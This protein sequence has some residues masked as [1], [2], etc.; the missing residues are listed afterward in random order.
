MMQQISLPKTILSE[1]TF[2]ALA[3]R[4]SHFPETT[5]FYSGGE[6]SL[7]KQ[8]FLA[9]FAVD[10]VII[11]QNTLN[12][13][14]YLQKRLLNI[15]SSNLRIPLWLGFFSYSLGEK[16][17][18][19]RGVAMPRT[20]FPFA[21]FHRYSYLFMYTHAQRTIELYYEPSQYSYWVRSF[22]STSFWEGLENDST[23]IITHSAIQRKRFGEERILYQQKLGIIARHLQEGN[24]YQV[25][26][27]HKFL[28]RG[29]ANP[30]SIFRKLVKKNP[31]PFSAYLFSRAF[32][33]VSSS[34]E[35]F[36]LKQGSLLEARP[37]KGT[38]PRGK[39]VEEDI[40]NK[41]NLFSSNKEKAELMMI[42]DLLRN[43][44]GKISQIGTVQV[45]DRQR[46]ESYT[47]VL[48]QLAIIQSQA[49]PS[50]HPLEIIRSCFP[51]GSIT[52]CPKLRAMEI[53]TELEEF[54]RDIYTGSMGMFFA[55]G[56]FTFNIAIR[57][58][59]FQKEEISI[60][61]GGGITIDSDPEQEYA[62]TLYKG[63]SIF[64]VL[65]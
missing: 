20:S 11:Y 5:L 17:D 52:G 9:I 64:Q 33:I 39:T 48:Q 26:Y 22:S 24:I 43:D 59:L 55:N 44:L 28:F 13:W 25:N 14:E 18:E 61:L 6:H 40:R 65:S 31:A 34:P 54:S 58:L 46:I 4:F 23:N 47:N 3:A 19:E 16:S 36:L 32:A 29:R 49:D 7:A 50:Y 51:G 37:I 1:A 8:S 30:F 15:G 45:I 12:P 63:E 53:I 60:H 2:I 35:L 57:T 10:S 41:A 38:A 27:A 42:I 62:E 56:D 21:Q